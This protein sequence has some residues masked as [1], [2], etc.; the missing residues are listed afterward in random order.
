MLARNYCPP[1]KPSVKLPS[2]RLVIFL[3]E[4]FENVGIFRAA[5]QR[6]YSST[7]SA[8]RLCAHALFCTVSCSILHK[9]VLKRMNIDSSS[10]SQ[11][12]E[13]S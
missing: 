2:R 10:I 3:F 11:A 5:T 8:V 6:D 7:H 12:E 9:D 1:P 4:V 13:G